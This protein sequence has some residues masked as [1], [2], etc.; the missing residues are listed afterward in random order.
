MVSEQ[1]KALLRDYIA[2]LEALRGAIS[3]LEDQVRMVELRISELETVKDV[4][5]KLPE[6]GDRAEDVLIP[7]GGGVF[8]RGTIKDV[9]RVLIGVGADIVVQKSIDEAV[10]DLDA[11]IENLKN[12]REELRKSIDD[13]TKQAE[14]LRARTEELLRKVREEA[15]K[16]SEKSESSG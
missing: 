8:V 14:E 1:E 12:S 2:Q 7:I 4:L 10:G 16:K 15:S 13:L 9:K 6:L 11:K 5:R 3:T